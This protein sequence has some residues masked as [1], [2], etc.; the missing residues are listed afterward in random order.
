MVDV[1]AC[2]YHETVF[3][4]RAVTLDGHNQAVVD[5]DWTRE[6]WFWIGASDVT[7]RNFRMLNTATK[8]QEGAIGTA[9]GTRNIVIDHNDLGPTANGMTIGIGGTTDSKVVNNSIHGAG[10]V[11]C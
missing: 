2:T 5:G 7:I 9:A 8:L 4:G 6:R 1:P 11:P 3:I 10:R